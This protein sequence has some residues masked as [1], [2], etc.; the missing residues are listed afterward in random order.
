[1]TSRN[2]HAEKNLMLTWAISFGVIALIAAALGFGGIAGA[3]AGIA[4]FLFFLFHSRPTAGAGRDA[5]DCGGVSVA[6]I[7]AGGLS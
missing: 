5:S 3:A 6:A 4:K 7:S 2:H 1:L